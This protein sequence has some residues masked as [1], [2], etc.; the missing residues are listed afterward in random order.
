M[1]WIARMQDHDL[2]FTT[3]FHTDLQYA[4][5]QLA[6]AKGMFPEGHPRFMGTYWGAVSWPAVAEVVESAELVLTVGCVWTDYSTVGYSLLLKPEKVC[7]SCGP[8]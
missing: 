6:D 7:V 2:I 3:L 1:A 4:V 5:A 8:L